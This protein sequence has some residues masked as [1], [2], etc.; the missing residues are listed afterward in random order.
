MIARF[1]MPGDNELVLVVD[2]RD[3]MKGVDLTDGFIHD[4]NWR[5]D[6]D[7]VR[8]MGLCVDD[9]D[10]TLP[11][12]TLDVPLSQSTQSQSTQSRAMLN[13]NETKDGWQ[14][15]WNFFD[16]RSKGLKLSHKPMM[17]EVK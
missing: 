3:R 12:N 4:S 9:D 16:P 10:Y 6:A 13:T 8:S 14:W 1:L 17:W 5:E 15:G 11:E 2:R 7:L